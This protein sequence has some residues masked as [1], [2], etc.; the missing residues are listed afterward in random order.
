M[1]SCTDG[2]KGSCIFPSTFSCHLGCLILVRSGSLRAAIMLREMMSNSWSV[3][4]RV[5]LLQFLI[6]LIPA[7]LASKIVHDVNFI[8][9]KPTI[10]WWSLAAVYAIAHFKMKNGLLFFV[11]GRRLNKLPQ[12][13]MGLSL[14]FIWMYM[15]LGLINILAAFLLPINIWIN[16]K[17]VLFFLVLVPIVFVVPGY[18][19]RK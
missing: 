10:L 17:L 19:E 18:L 3:F 6:T 9:W 14:C 7:V 11:W 1:A 5:I 4:W 8:L 2:R 12:F 13:W 16:F 15:T